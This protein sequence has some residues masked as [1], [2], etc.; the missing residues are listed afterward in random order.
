MLVAEYPLLESYSLREAVSR[1]VVVDAEAWL[2][3]RYPELKSAIFLRLYR[4]KVRIETLEALPIVA[5][6]VREELAIMYARRMRTDDLNSAANFFKSKSGRAYANV[7]IDHD[8][9]IAR[10]WL[11]EAYKSMFPRLEAL[12]AEAL[13]SERLIQKVNKP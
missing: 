12:V 10:L 3:S 9:E 1:D 11:S 13:D 2:S 7:A 5:P 6:R 8:A 4:E